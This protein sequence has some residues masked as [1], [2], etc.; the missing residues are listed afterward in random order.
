M[1]NHT[2]KYNIGLLEPSKSCFGEDG[3]GNCFSTTFDKIKAV[4][5]SHESGPCSV[6]SKDMSDCLRLLVCM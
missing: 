1:G 3:G 6:K 5:S 4:C 2:T